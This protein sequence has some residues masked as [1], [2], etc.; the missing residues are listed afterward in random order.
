MFKIEEQ[1]LQE[2]GTWKKARHRFYELE[3]T[4]EIYWKR[5]VNAGGGW[6]KGS[7]RLVAFQDGKQIRVHAF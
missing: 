5:H 7:K 6:Y 2:D 4:F 1:W 3:K